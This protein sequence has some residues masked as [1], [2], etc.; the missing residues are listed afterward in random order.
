MKKRILS[1]ILVAA[2][3][4]TMFATTAFAAEA[5]GRTTVIYDNRKQ[6]TDPDHGNNPQWAVNIP[7]TIIFTDNDKEIATDV[8]LTALNGS[9]IEATTVEVKVTST[10][11]YVM[12]LGADNTDDPVAYSLLYNDTVMSGE[13]ASVGSLTGDG[14]TISGVARMTGTATKAGE[15]TDT[16]TYYASAN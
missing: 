5:E 8:E 7:S 10:K 11:D 12:S 1:G 16:L 6:I 3:A 14:A 4:T 13:K 9:N 2:M 15:H